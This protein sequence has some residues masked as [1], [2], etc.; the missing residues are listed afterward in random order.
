MDAALLKMILLAA[1]V[2]VVTA[3]IA[4]AL[5]I[6]SAF[7]EKT[8]SGRVVGGNC[9]VSGLAGLAEDLRADPKDAKAP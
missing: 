8:K 3:A 1:V 7:S 9:C 5:R 4:K 6:G 2:V